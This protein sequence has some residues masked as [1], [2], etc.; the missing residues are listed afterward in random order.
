[1]AAIIPVLSQ[2]IGLCFGAVSLVRIHRAR[3]FGGG[4]GGVKWAAVGIASSGF[5]LLCW[6]A[7]FLV[8]GVVNSSLWQSSDTLSELL[9]VTP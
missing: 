3:R 4:L 5:A 1:V 9:Q 2:V 8:F 7:I 6:I